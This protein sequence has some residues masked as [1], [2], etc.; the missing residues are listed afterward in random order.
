[1]SLGM[2]LNYYSQPPQRFI[3]HASLLILR[4]S[5]EVFF[6][7]GIINSILSY[8]YASIY[9][10]T[11]TTFWVSSKLINVTEFVLNFPKNL[12]QNYDIDSVNALDIL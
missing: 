5:A 7:K 2:T 11:Y 6:F 10:L 1:M 8:I 3:M 9:L 12:H 4:I